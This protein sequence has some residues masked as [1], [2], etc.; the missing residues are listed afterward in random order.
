MYTE[1]FGL[2]ENSFSI[3]PDP[4]YLYLS[5][6]HREAL[7]HLLYG[8]GEGGG[9]VLLTGEVGTGK[10]TV[11]RAFLEQRPGEL[12][13]ALILN[14][15]LSVNELLQSI[16]QEFGVEVPAEAST[17]KA[18]LDCLN[19]YL[20][21]AH[22]ANRRPVLLIDE[23]QNLAR[24]VLEQIRLL[25]NLETD[26][27]KLLQ[28]F[29]IGQ[30]E[31][32]ELLKRED[33]RQLAQRITARYHLLP[34]DANETAE[35][36]QHRLAVAGGKNKLFEKKA[37]KRVHEL[38]GGIPRLINILC[39]RALLG[40]YATQKKSVDARIVDQAAKEL[41]GEGEAQLNRRS[42][43]LWL[44]LAL[45]LIALLGYYWPSVKQWAAPS[46]SRME[47]QQPP[48]S[49]QIQALPKLEL[50]SPANP[51]A[52]EPN[53]PS[54]VNAHSDPNSIRWLNQQLAQL[55]YAVTDQDQ[56]AE[57]AVRQFQTDQHLSVDGIAG[58]GTLIRLQALMPEPELSNLE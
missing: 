15:S 53:R 56:Y 44:L 23:A 36:V 35:Y 19:Q 27:A 24:D 46:Q 3:T 38:T 4:H 2:T 51:V 30:P 49:G 16:C 48:S 11:C 28:I 14:P 12:D 22:A 47:Q 40:A 9:F 55:G 8:A 39:D 32:K 18:L 25:T 7:A 34:L 29:L 52:V 54:L 21:A 10:T 43:W 31:L 42:I 6:R 33:L 37:L 26:K 41:A 13:I 20:L 17:N 58:S 57:E 5:A 50:E 1:H 45:A